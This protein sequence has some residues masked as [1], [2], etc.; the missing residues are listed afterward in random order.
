MKLGV[1]DWLPQFDP[2]ASADQP[3]IDIAAARRVRD[4]GFRGSSLYIA[5][6]LETTLDEVRRIKQVFD[7]ADLEIAQLNGAYETLCNPDDDLR[8]RGVTGVRM[9]CRFARA[10]EAHSLY[11]RP[12]GLNPKGPWLPH[13]GNHTQELFDRVV[14]SLRKICRV[15]EHEGV[16]LA[17][18]GHVVSTLDTPRRM[19]ELIDT[20]YLIIEHLPEDQALQGRDYI[21]SIARQLGVLLEQ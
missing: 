8:A 15:A 9:L 20:G 4:A 7:A 17:I 19:R 11:A 14:D 12:G 3:R 13:P 5:R 2:A 6:P 18:E 10:V 1:A 21:V 16:I